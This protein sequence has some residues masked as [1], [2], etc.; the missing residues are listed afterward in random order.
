MLSAEYHR[1]RAVEDTHWWYAVL[2]G[3]VLRE[4]HARVPLGARVLDVGCGTGGML[5]RLADWQ[6]TGIDVSPL[7]VRCCQQRGLTQV[8]EG[9]VN[10]LPFADHS[11]DAVLCLDVLYHRDVDEARALR[12]MQRVLVPGG[13]IIVNVPAF[14]SLRGPHDEAVCGVRRYTAC[15]VQ[16]LLAGVSLDAEMTHYWNAWLMLPLM[17]KRRWPRT[18]T[19]DLAMPPR[20]LN[21]LLSWIGRADAECCR[22]LRLPVG[23]SVFAVAHKHPLSP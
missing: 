11:F 4:L 13:R 10:R 6:A 15:H 16:R 21:T 7:A 2:R 20:W 3:L 18:T 19:S 17:I 1:L 9:S 12:E 5:A 14:E 22:R 8:I 23:S